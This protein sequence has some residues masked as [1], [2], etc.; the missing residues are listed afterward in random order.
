MHELEVHV[1]MQEP[2]FVIIVRWLGLVGLIATII[3]GLQK[4][5]IDNDALMNRAVWILL[6]GGGIGLLVSR[7]LNGICDGNTDQHGREHKP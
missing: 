3:L 1:S 7:S 2:D 5:S 4:G 6:A